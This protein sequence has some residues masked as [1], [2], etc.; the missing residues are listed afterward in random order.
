[1]I[2]KLVSLSDDIRLTTIWYRIILRVT[3]YTRGF[4]METLYTVHEAA[5][6]LKVKNPTMYKYMDRGIRGVRLAYINVGGTRRIRQSAIDAFI[7]ASTAAGELADDVSEELPE[8]Y[9][10]DSNETPTPALV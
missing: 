6:Y 7:V 4:A 10:K 9:T 8:V 3:T 2:V 1:M 5:E